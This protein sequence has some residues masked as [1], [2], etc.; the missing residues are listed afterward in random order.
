MQPPRTF[1]H[2]V[3][4]PYKSS[5][6]SEIIYPFSDKEVRGREVNLPVQGHGATNANKEWS[7]EPIPGHR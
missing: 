3:F 4:D 2:T 5:V 6:R 1:L 7:Q